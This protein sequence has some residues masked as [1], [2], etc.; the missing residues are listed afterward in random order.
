MAEMTREELT[1]RQERVLLVGVI[2]PDGTADP[3]DPLGELRSLAKTAGAKVADEMVAKRRMPHVKCYVGAGKAEEIAQR[4]EQNEIDAII[5]DNDLTPSQIRKLEEITECKVLDRSE[6]ILDIFANHAQSS[7]SRL[8]V[9]L[10]QLEYTYPR[11][12]GMWTHL[13]RH[14]GGVGTRGPG[15][16]QIETDRRIV[17]K[18]VGFLKSKLADIDRRKLREVKGRNDTFCVCLVGYTNAGKST[19]MNLLTGTGTYVADQLF[20][21]LETKT[22]RWN[23]SQHTDVLLSDTIGFVRDLP[24]HLVA[25]FRAT[26]EEAIHADLLI[27]V[28]DASSHRVAQQIQAVD[29]VLDDLGCDR[30]R[31]LLVLNKIDQIIDP[32]IF[33][34]LNSEF[35]DALHVSAKTGRGADA[36]IQAVAKRAEG[37]PVR[38]KM[39]ANYRN[40]RLMQFIAQH[41]NVEQQ[42]Y[43]DSVTCI[44]AIITADKLEA[45]QYFGN[46]VEILTQ[47]AP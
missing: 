34:I 18:R 26:L 4:C 38:I 37:L 23:L 24:H 20:A 15:E 39:E 43:N 36:V 44:E 14:G 42:T 30:S 22:R 3:R 13:D 7:Q 29:K 46:D 21:T 11:L 28:A 40:G 12:S 8:Q 25:S 9:E 17:Q 33:T 41:A 16:R 32:T 1:V 35:P 10:A 31:E 27:H 45:I 2:L 6:L 5:F 19:L 47:T